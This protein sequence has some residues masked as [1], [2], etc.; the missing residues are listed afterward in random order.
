MSI[1]DSWLSMMLTLVKNE[2]LELSAMI[3]ASSI[4]PAK[5]LGLSQGIHIGQ[6][7]N[8]ILVNQHTEVC[9]H[10]EDLLS[11]GKNSPILGTTLVGQVQLTMSAGR[12][13]YRA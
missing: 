6:P 7:A 11:S 12:Q 8:L 2:E 3:N 4:L 1:L 9:Y 10:Q 5:I 13:V